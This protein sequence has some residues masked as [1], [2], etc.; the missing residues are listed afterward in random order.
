[1]KNN[2]CIYLYISK[3]NS[4]SIIIFHSKL[5]SL[6]FFQMFSNSL[7]ADFLYG[8]KTG[9][10]IIWYI[11]CIWFSESLWQKKNLLI[12]GN[13]FFCHHVLNS[14]SIIKLSLTHID[15]FWRLCSRHLFENKLTKI[16]IAQNEQLLLLPQCFSLLV[17]GN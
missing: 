8:R 4:Y 2:C 7:A 13:L 12:N 15:A 3:F 17:I 11:C 5:F 16:E 9:F 10:I 14:F 6:I 1:M